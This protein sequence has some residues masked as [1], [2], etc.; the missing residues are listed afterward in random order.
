M[1]P[2]EAKNILNGLVGSMDDLTKYVSKTSASLV[3]NMTPEQ[4]NIFK[5][6]ME[7][8]GINKIHA[9]TKKIKTEF[10]QMFEKL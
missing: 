10:K 8:A 7:A 6:Q 1:N 2:N 4:A 3:K 9:D 5:Q